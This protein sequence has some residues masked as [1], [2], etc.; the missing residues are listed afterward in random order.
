MQIKEFLPNPAGKDQDGEYITLENTGTVGVNLDG[1]KLKD[2]SGKTYTIRG[3]TLSAGEELTLP[4]KTTRISLNNTSE[5]VQL[6]NAAGALVDELSFTGGAQEGRV[7]TRTTELTPELKT[8]LFEPLAL[9]SLPSRINPSEPIG[10]L[11]VLIVLAGA[12][13]AGIGV[14]ILRTHEKADNHLKERGGN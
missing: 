7:I 8:E 1:W 9:A 2:A 13:L 11:V 14:W 6:V 3:K 4:Y 12:I 10:K 5:T